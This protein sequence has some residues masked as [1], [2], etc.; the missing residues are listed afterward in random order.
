MGWVLLSSF[1]RGWERGS[2]SRRSGVSHGGAPGNEGAAALY[3]KT[4]MSP[5]QH[6]LVPNHRTTCTFSPQAGQAAAGGT[7]D[8][9]R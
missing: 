3:P 9:R 6:Q 8:C 1:Y 7:F 5:P 4:V 2:N